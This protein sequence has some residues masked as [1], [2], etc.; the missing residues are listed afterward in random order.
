MSKKPTILIVDND[1]DVIH[2]LTVVLEGAGYAVTAAESREQAE[3]VLLGL[4]P[5]VAI[6]D[7]MMEEMDSGFVL[8]HHVKQ[9]YP[10]TPIMLL[11]AVTSATGMSFGAQTPEAR[12]W[13]KADCVL[14][15]PVR[16]DQL[17][18]EVRRLLDRSKQTRT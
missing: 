3:E 10:E 13:L 18:A 4:K 1:P 7:L 9:L 11:T 16:P 5:D 12:S 17:R 6:L 15:K 14:D 2:Q 8:A